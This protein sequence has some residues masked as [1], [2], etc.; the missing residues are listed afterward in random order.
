MDHREF[1]AMI[2]QIMLDGEINPSAYAGIVNGGNAVHMNALGR[3]V[4]NALHKS[5]LNGPYQILVLANVLSATLR[6]QETPKQREF[7]DRLFDMHKVVSLDAL[8]RMA[9]LDAANDG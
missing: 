7:L 2:D 5:P 8:D 1:D 6:A 3:K 4:M 9:G